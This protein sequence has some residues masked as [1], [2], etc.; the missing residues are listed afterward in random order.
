MYKISFALAL[1]GFVAAHGDEEEGWVP[2]DTVVGV[3]NWASCTA[4]DDCSGAE[5]VCA[6]AY[7]KDQTTG[8]GG[9]AKGCQ[10]A[11][12][13]QGSGSW[14]WGADKFA[15]VCSDAQKQKGAGLT[16]L[17]GVTAID[18]IPEVQACASTSDCGDG[19]ACFKYFLTMDEDSTIYDNGSACFDEMLVEVCKEPDHNIGGV[20]NFRNAEYDGLREYMIEFDCGDIEV[21]GS[22]A[23]ALAASLVAL[24]YL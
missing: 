4:D 1:A 10:P 15:V 22:G 8:A 7:W 9:R 2:Q 20:M 12:L 5:L 19:L 13:C 11:Q 3:A 14:A 16:P 21:Q 17:Q 6:E 18:A 23:A 24:V